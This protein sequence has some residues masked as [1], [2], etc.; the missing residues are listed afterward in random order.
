MPEGIRR[1]ARSQMERAGTLLGKASANGGGQTLHEARQ[2]LKKA[3]A[4][5]RL[6][7]PELGEEFWRREDRKLR[8]IA[9]GLARRRDAEVLVATVEQLRPAQAN[10]GEDRIWAKL[11]RI[12]M[13]RREKT[14]GGS[15]EE[16]K[17][18][19]RAL[20]EARRRVR[21]WPLEDAD[22]GGLC[23]GVGR[24]YREGGN[25]MLKAGRTH[26]TED[27]HEWRKRVKDLWY[28][29]RILEPL[30]P[31]R[32]V[33]LADGMKKLSKQLGDDHDLAVLEEAV[34]KSKLDPDEIKTVLGRVRARRLGSQRE[35]FKLGQRLFA[36]DAAK[37]TRPLRSIEGGGKVNVGN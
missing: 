10:P 34:K 32:M 21:D 6:A 16:R 23:R 25:A 5:L 20:R 22:L 30:Q 4:T 36:T 19:R 28:E 15:R 33:K 31:K 24:V 3:R 18:Y 13:K 2:W 9:R 12:F 27:L 14:L 35:A 1:I 8:K 37:F 17:K 29:F 11:R 7:R 26:G